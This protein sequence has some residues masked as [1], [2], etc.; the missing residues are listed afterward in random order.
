MYEDLKG[1]KLLIVG[2][3]M[4]DI[5]IVR[6]AQ[7]MGVYTIAMDWSTDYDK[8]PAKKVADEAWDMNYRDVEAVSKRCIE[9]NVEGVMAGYSEMRVLLAAQI[10]K[11]IGKPFYVT[12]EIM[13]MTRDKRRF[14]ELCVEYGVP[15]PREFCVSG[16]PTED[17]IVKVKFPVIVKPSDYGGRIGI[18][19]CKN[20]EQLRSAVQKALSVSEKKEVVVEEYIT[21]TEMCAVYNLSD[22]EIEL[23]LLNDKYQVIVNN[24]RTVLCNA[25]VVP[26]VHLDEFLKKADQPIKRF[27]HGIGAQN[28]MAFFQMIVNEDGIYIF[29]MGYRLN[30]GNDC[31]VIEQFNHINHMKMMISYSLTGSMGDDIKKNNPRFEGVTVSFLFYVHGGT[32]GEVEYSG[33]NDIP[34]IFSI[35]QKVFP[36]NVVIEDGTTRQEALVIKLHGA[37]MEEVIGIIQKAQKC[38]SF[39]DVSGN[40]MLFDHFDT[41][42]LRSDKW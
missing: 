26:S 11:A 22:G 42:R 32:V 19:I 1:K 18:S 3:D 9:E 13:E 15:V 8:S 24:A 5:E 39:N 33:L 21:G 30:G 35:T 29:E 20:E 40:S 23:A 17:E 31:H 14:K 6:T 25:T 37:D 36:G 34:E 28:G 2:A 27:L 7:S 16:K 41:S 38:V 10:S 4:N 12:E